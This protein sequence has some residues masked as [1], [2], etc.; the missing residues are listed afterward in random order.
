MCTVIC[1][2]INHAFNDNLYKFNFHIEDV[3]C[4]LHY[5][6]SNNILDHAGTQPI[7]Y[8]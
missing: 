6:L 5:M 8:Q 4:S 1:W 3:D 7:V 2:N